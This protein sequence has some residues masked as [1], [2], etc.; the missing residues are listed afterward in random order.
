MD[1][2]I[3]VSLLG[4]PRVERDGVLVAF[5]TRKALAVLAL[6][7]LADRPRTRDG[8]ADLLWPGT[9]PAHARGA[10]RRT[11]STLRSAVGADHLEATS[12]HVR[13]VKRR[14][15]RRRRGP[16]PR[17][18]APTADVEGA[19]GGSSAA[20]FLEG[21]AV[22]DAPDFEDWVRGRRGRPAPRAHQRAGRADRGARGG[23]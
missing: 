18:G 23:R 16:V 8:L 3:E 21:F 22:R 17:P 7:A 10:L 5:D 6:L 13:L 9:D 14:R 4:P 2:V 11:L 19:A 20:T 15:P 1:S 12:D